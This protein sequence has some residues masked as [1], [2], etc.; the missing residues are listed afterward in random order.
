[1]CRDAGVLPDTLGNRLDQ[2]LRDIVV[3]SGDSERRR[4]RF[5]LRDR[6]ARSCQVFTEPDL[7]HDEGREIGEQQAI[8]RGPLAW[9]R[10]D[11]ANRT[12]HVSVVAREGV[13]GV[14][15]HAQFLH[16]GV[17]GEQR[18]PPGVFD[19]KRLAGSHDVLADRM[20]ERDLAAREPRLREAEAALQELAT[21]VDDR[22]ERGWDAKHSQREARDP[23]EGGFDRGVQEGSPLDR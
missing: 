6:L 17:F 8:V 16:G 7:R 3:S 19:E 14:G 20:R 22:D 4:R 21:F 12:Q 13:A 1:M 15:R 23:V 9:F 11:G 18:M 5:A 10:V 2:V